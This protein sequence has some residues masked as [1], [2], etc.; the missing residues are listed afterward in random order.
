[1]LRVAKP[2]ASQCTCDML[3]SDNPETVRIREISQSCIGF[4]AEEHRIKTK[5]RMRLARVKKALRESHEWVNALAE[6]RVD[7]EM[8]HQLNWHLKEKEN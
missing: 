1:M 6:L 2:F 8:R 7:M 5:F 4:V 3:L